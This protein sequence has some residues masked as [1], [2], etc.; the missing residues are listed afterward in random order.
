MSNL[1]PPSPLRRTTDSRHQSGA[2]NRVQS[3]HSSS[4]SSSAQLERTKKSKTPMPQ[5]LTKLQPRRNLKLERSF[6]LV[7][8]PQLPSASGRRSQPAGHWPEVNFLEIRPPRPEF[9]TAFDP[10]FNLPRRASRRR[11][12]GRK[13]RWRARLAIMFLHRAYGGPGPFNLPGTWSM[14]MRSMTSAVAVV[15]LMGLL[16]GRTSAGAES[17]GPPAIEVSN[18]ALLDL[19]G[20]L[21]ELRRAEGKAVVLFFTTNGCPV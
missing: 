1:H 19:T 15:V 11:R 3:K 5:Q 20:K 6:A 12:S 9:P 18:F 10:L 13:G 8:R 16:V 2:L 7:L 21:H 17:A 14:S 4:R